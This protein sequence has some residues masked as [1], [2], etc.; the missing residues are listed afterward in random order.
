M[1]GL[2]SIV[3]LILEE[4][5]GEADGILADAKKQADELLGEADR[6]AQSQVEEKRAL[7]KKH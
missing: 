6:E 2:D 4:A 3:A 7:A 5:K 1:N